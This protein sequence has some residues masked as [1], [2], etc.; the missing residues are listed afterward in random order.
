MSDAPRD[1]AEVTYGSLI[2]T[3]YGE[4]YFTTEMVR[5]DDVVALEVATF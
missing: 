2:R 5:V 3:R 1:D 4:P